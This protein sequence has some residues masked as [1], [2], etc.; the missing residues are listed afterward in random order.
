[1]LDSP[2]L[3]QMAQKVSYVLDYV[4]LAELNLNSPHDLVFTFLFLLLP[5]HHRLDYSP[6][7]GCEV[8]YIR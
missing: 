6:L 7:L 8:G 4:P 5:H 1:M 3:D 2:T